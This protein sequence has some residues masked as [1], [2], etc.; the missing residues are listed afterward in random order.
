M[1]EPRRI[2][3]REGGQAMAGQTKLAIIGFVVFVALIVSGRLGGLYVDWLWFQSVGLQAVFATRFVAQITLF[4]VAALAFFAIFIANVVIALR[5]ASR[6]D[7]YVD[8]MPWSQARQINLLLRLG[9]IGAGI[10]LAFLVASR[11]A[12]SWEVVL[13]FLNPTSFGVADPLFGRDLSFFVFIL[14]MYG[15]LEGWYLATILLTL[16]GC[17]AVYA[18]RFLL[19]QVSF[20][21]GAMESQVQNLKLNLDFGPGIKAHLSVLVALLALGFAWQGWLGIYELVYSPTGLVFGAGYADANARLPVMWLLVGIAVLFAILVLVNIGR[22]GYGLVAYALAAWIGIAI[23]GGAIYPGIVQRLQVLPSELDKERPYIENNVNLTSQAYALDRINEVDYPAEDAVTAGEVDGNPATIKNIRLWDP[24]PLLNTYNQIQSIRL[25]YDFVDVDVDR[26]VIDGEYRQVMLAARELSPGKLASQAQTWVNR[27]LQFTH[28][29]G[30]A[31]SP[32]NEVTPEGLP[33]LF[34]QDVPPRGKLSLARP[35]IYYGENTNDQVIVKTTTP[36]FDYPKGDDNVY[37]EYQGN[38]GVAL[39]SLLRRLLFAWQFGDVNIL[40]SGSITSESMI[41]YNRNIKERAKMVAPF[42][43]YDRDPYIVVADDHLYWV[44]DAYT[45]TDRYPYS[46]PVSLGRGIKV[47]YLRNSVKVVIDAYEGDMRF[48]LADSSDPIIHTYAAIFPGLFVPLEEMPQALRSHL[49]Y[50]QDLFNVQAEL[51]RTYHM[52]DARVFYNK[53]DLWNIPNEVYLDKPVP[54]QPYYVIMRLPGE[55]REEFALILPYTPPNKNNM[56]TWL[57]AR[58]DGD[59]YGKLVAYKYPKDK[60]IYG[61]M[62]IEARIDQDPRISEQLTLWNQ[63]GSRVMRGNMIVIPIGKSNLYVEPIYLQSEQ[64]QLPEMKRVVLA[65]GNRVIMEPTV[66]IGLRRLF[67]TRAAPAAPPVAAGAPAAAPAPG[68]GPAT[69]V[70]PPPEK[71]LSDAAKS[72]LDRYL[73][74]QEDMKAMES[75]LRRL[76]EAAESG[77]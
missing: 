23:L 16:L 26:Y 64:T 66:D 53:E 3:P 51:Y 61:P 5:L 40:F 1:D 56:I 58:S 57:A 72:L 41:L 22:R 8:S 6:Y 76:L 37:V 17:L 36:E 10:L 54:M 68:V 31:M 33:E 14:P 65:T 60:L 52:R 15:L 30:V 75:D 19:P 71:K 46:Q 63:A 67:P 13:R 29:Y 59:A 9:S 50:P 74:L 48:Y 62:Q 49:R 44:L 27:R 45:Q 25:Y 55:E 42:L 11:I 28:G 7:A 73:K 47:N 77:R 69:G 20:T 39:G 12:S 18:V 38:S 35:E 70:T 24:E 2:G 4:V 43:S 21:E 32:V 34:V